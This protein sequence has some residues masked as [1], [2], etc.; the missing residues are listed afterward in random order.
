M[1][2]HVAAALALACGVL[3][4]GWALAAEDVG[5]YESAGA[6]ETVRSYWIVGSQGLLIL[7]AQPGNSQAEA[8][9]REAQARTARKAVMA[10][11]LA[12]V[13]AQYAGAAAL[14]KH[15]VKVY[16]SQQVADAVAARSA[17][18]GLPRPTKRDASAGAPKLASFGDTGRQMLIAGVQFHVRPLGP[19]SAVAHVV[20]EYDNRLFAGDLVS[21][22]VHP[23]LAGGSL[24]AWFQRLR[25]LQ[26]RKPRL[27][28][29]ASGQPGGVALIANQ[30]IYI[31]QLMD[32]I[33][34]ESPRGPATVEALARVKDKMLQAYPNYGAPERLDALIAQEWRRQAGSAQQ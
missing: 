18:A 4:G 24:D 1:T 10:V 21:G 13:P 32:F 7:G 15:D 17:Q 14:Q 3:S 23:Q 2:R 5:W 25:E 34:Q 11:V 22:P 27:I 33:A 26:M 19:G 30:M 20:V 9:L 29:P 8:L 28:Y 12:P 16:T 6:G 31:K